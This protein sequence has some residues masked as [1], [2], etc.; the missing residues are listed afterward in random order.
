MTDVGRW[1]RAADPLAH[2]PGLSHLQVAAMRRA[3]IAAAERHHAAAA[4]PS[5]LMVATAIA[6]TLVAGVTI[7][8][9]FPPGG[10]ETAGFGGAV[11]DVAGTR[12]LQYA[13]RGGTRII[14]VFDSEFQP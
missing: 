4:W 2:E 6:A 9:R 12:Q 8:R 10:Q 14:W 11:P 1:L 13:T 5:A 3:V 7:G